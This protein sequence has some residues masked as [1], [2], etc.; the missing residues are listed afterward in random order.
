MSL[1]PFI[2]GLLAVIALSHSPATAL[3]AEFDLDLYAEL[4]A[5]HTRAVPTTVG[6][7]VDYRGLRDSPDWRRLSQQIRTARPS[8]LSGP[9]RLAFWINAYNILT[10]DLIL[11]NYP[12]QGGA[13]G[14]CT[15][16]G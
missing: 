4:L 9:E 2:G 13:G 3:S 10:I 5:Q 1:R 14:R 15:D 16:D 7:V 12:V 8:R 11:E 6:T